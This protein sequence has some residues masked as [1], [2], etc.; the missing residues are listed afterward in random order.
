MS[1]LFQPSPSKIRNQSDASSLRFFKKVGWCKI[2]QITPW[3]RRPYVADALSFVTEEVITLRR[4]FL[5]SRSTCLASRSLF[6]YFIL[7]NC[8][9]SKGDNIFSSFH[10]YDLMAQRSLLFCHPL[11]N[12]FDSIEVYFSGKLKAYFVWTFNQLIQCFLES[13]LFV[14][15]L[16][17]H[18]GHVELKKEESGHQYPDPS[19]I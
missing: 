19:R 5:C 3:L 15:I 12:L 7:K 6:R 10:A 8:Q 11:Q 16:G 17:L 14:S 2:I 1:S 9:E 18:A 4:S 13:Y